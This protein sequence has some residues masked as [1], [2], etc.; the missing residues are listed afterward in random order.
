VTRTRTPLIV[1]AT[2]VASGAVPDRYDPQA[3]WDSTMSA[4]FT[5]RGI[6][7]PTFPE[8]LNEAMYRSMRDTVDRIVAG[9]GLAGNLGTRSVLDVGSGIGLWIKYWRNRGA[10]RVTGL[11]ITS[12][13]FERL[14]ERFPDVELVR[15]DIGDDRLELDEQFDVVSA[16]NML[17]HV[18]DD[19]RWEQAL[20]NLSRLCR[21]GGVLLIIDPV[22][23]AHERG[24]ALDETAIERRRHVD[25]WRAVLAKNGMEIVRTEPATVLLATP[26]DTRTRV[27]YIA[28][29]TYWRALM[30]LA[31][32]RERVGAVLGRPIQL[33]D[34]L[35]IRIVPRGSTSKCLVVRHT[36]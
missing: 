10:G 4:D 33:L 18:T 2:E 7:F 30:K 15:A 16:M 6:A 28:L 9:E 3:F 23:F 14:R 21:P 1:R 8:S 5:I 12:E 22:V 34:R 19:G 11:D 17:L 32:G 13:G 20:A 27:G 24:P 29:W 35:L 31:S 26:L 25:R 36:R